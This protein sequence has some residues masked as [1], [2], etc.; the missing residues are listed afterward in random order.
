[1]LTEENK[2]DFI[3]RY[4][5]GKLSLWELAE[6][7]DRIKTDHSF[8][9][10]VRFERDVLI[11]IRES[12]RLELKEKLTQMSANSSI[13]SLRFEKATLIRY[14]IA[15]SITLLVTGSILYQDITNAMIPVSRRGHYSGQTE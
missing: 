12:K 13:F 10:E 9:Q 8:A 4:L 3:E 15:A 7:E 14:A 2:E 6:I 5:F 1:M 11:G